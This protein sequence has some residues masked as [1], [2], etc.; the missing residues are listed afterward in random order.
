M[1][2]GVSHFICPQLYDDDEGQ[3]PLHMAIVAG[4]LDVVEILIRDASHHLDMKSRDEGMT[5]LH[6]AAQ[7]GHV[8]ILQALLDAGASVDIVDF[9]GRMPL[10]R[11]LHEGHRDAANMLKEE[12]DGRSIDQ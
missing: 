11:A 5:A 3:T 7:G 2:Q 9:E 8:A 1:A 4:H 10:Y 12:E 6:Y